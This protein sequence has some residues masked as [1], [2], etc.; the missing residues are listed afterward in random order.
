MRA[1][2][3]ATVL[4]LA[5]LAHAGPPARPRPLPAPAPAIPVVT[6]CWLEPRWFYTLRDGA[7]DYCKQHLRYYK[8]KPDCLAFTD[9]I[10]WAYNPDTGEWFQLRNNGDQRVVICPDGPEPPTCPR[11]R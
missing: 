2:L 11:L 5:V 9:E 6:S 4:L 1:I 3:T 7:V 10:C 8:G